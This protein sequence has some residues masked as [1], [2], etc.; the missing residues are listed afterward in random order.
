MFTSYVTQHNILFTFACIWNLKNR[1]MQYFPFRNPLV[2]YSRSY[3]VKSPS[4]VPTPSSLIPV[5]VHCRIITQRI[6]SSSYQW[7]FRWFWFFCHTNKMEM[8]YSAH[9]QVILMT[10]NANMNLIS[11]STSL[12][13]TGSTS[14]FLKVVP[15]YFH[16]WTRLDVVRFIFN[17]QA[18]VCNIIFPWGCI[19]I[20]LMINKPEHLT[21]W[22]LLLCVCLCVCTYGFFF[23][24]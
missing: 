2:K 5:M 13:S 3:S 10:C 9:V 15:I 22:P 8:T 12:N 19:C 23:F 1:I 20:L 7:M 16:Q 14:C 4:W 18:G 6:C 17:S 11:L 21:R 24:W